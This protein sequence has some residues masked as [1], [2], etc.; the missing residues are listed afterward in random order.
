MRIK[1]RFFAAKG[2]D[3]S[4]SFA[5]WQRQVL[6]VRRVA[7]FGQLL[8]AQLHAERQARQAIGH[9]H[10]QGAQVVDV[11]RWPADEWHAALAAQRG[12]FWIIEQ[13]GAVTDP[14]GSE[15]L[16]RLAD[17]LARSIEVLV[18]VQL[19]QL[20][21]RAFVD[22]RGGDDAAFGAGA[23]AVTTGAVILATQKPTGTLPITIQIEGM[24]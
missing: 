20:V 8:D 1:W 17:L 23:A 5:I 18:R 7:Q 3:Y 14:L 19:H 11:Q 22:V 9:Q 12:H 10:A 15:D 6:G 16:D 4:A 13:G 24:P 2:F 21:D